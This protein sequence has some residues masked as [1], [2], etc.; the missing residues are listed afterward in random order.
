MRIL[1]LFVD[2]SGDFGTYTPHSPY[3]L[4]SLVM[5]GQDAP[6]KDAVANLDKKIHEH[7]FDPHAIHTG[8]IVRNEGFYQ[9]YSFVERKRL[10][11]DLLLFIRQIEI[12]YHCFKIDKKDCAGSNQMVEKLSKQFAA[13]IKDHLVYFSSFDRIVVYYDYGQS[14]ITTILT[15][16]LNSLINDVEFRHVQPY[17]YKLFQVADMICTLELVKIKYD[18]NTV[19]NSEQHFYGTK[20]NFK[21]YYYKT[22]TK[23]RM[24]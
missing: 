14:E 5:H 4:F 19:S 17:Q 21:D 8:P 9:N 7:G 20:K 3:Y 18:T 12:S 11:N 16:V 6:I 24:E 10:F 23:K 22:I 2:K 1:S 15:S 13:F